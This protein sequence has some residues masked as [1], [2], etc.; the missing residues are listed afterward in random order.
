[1]RSFKL[2][3]VV[4]RI[5]WFWYQTG[6]AIDPLNYNAQFAT[7]MNHRTRNHFETTNYPQYD[8]NANRTRINKQFK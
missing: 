4:F 8:I 5:Y 1:M 2:V 7:A 3:V 6:K